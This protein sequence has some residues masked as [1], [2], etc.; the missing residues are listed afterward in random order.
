MK[1]LRLRGYTKK[2]KVTTTR[3]G[4]DPRK[5]DTMGW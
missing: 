3:R 5:V 1:K 2:R 4:L